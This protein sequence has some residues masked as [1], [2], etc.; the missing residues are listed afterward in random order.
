MNIIER[1]QSQNRNNP[2]TQEELNVLIY[3]AQDGCCKSM[4]TIILK[5]IGLVMA[6]VN[7][8]SYSNKQN[9]DDYFQEGCIGMMQAIKKFDPTKGFKFSTYAAIWINQTSGEWLKNTSN[10]VRIPK[11][12]YGKI[13]HEYVPVDWDI[14]SK[15]DFQEEIDQFELQ[16]LIKKLTEKE[17][18]VVNSHLAGETFI[19]IS[20]REGVCKSRAQAIFQ[21]AKDKMKG[22]ITV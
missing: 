22:L 12:H 3:K 1:Q 16:D 15:N 18:R 7:K 20:K 11:D 5:N 4:N 8:Y 9:I 6:L 2:L 13:K 19:T 21:E 10:T 14:A 17:Q